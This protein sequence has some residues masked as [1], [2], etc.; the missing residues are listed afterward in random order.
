MREFDSDSKPVITDEFIKFIETFEK[1]IV[2]PI[3][4]GQS[5]DVQGVVCGKDLGGDSK[6][7]HGFNIIE[8]LHYTHINNRGDVTPI[9]GGLPVFRIT[10]NTC[11]YLML[12]SYKRI[13]AIIDSNAKTKSNEGNVGE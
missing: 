13:R 7:Y 10:C 12:F 4:R 1:N 11:A 6:M 9:G 8:S 2:C 5:W 3:C